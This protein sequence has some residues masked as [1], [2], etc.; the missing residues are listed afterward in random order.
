MGIEP[1]KMIKLICEGSNNYDIL[2]RM[3]EKEIVAELE[4]IP[5]FV[6]TSKGPERDGTWIRLEGLTPLDE[7]VP[8]VILRKDLRG[9]LILPHHPADNVQPAQRMP[10]RILQ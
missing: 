10:P 5:E 3:P 6:T 9:Y 1:V 4:Y 2:T 7:R 8:V